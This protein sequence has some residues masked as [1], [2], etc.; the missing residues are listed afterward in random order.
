MDLSEV[1][2]EQNLMKMKVKKGAVQRRG[3]KVYQDQ[4]VQSGVGTQEK[5]I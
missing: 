2:F 3:R 5:V 4:Q 1:I